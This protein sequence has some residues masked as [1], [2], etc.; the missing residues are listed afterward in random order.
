MS[1]DRWSQDD[2]E[3][4]R[5]PLFGDDEPTASNEILGDDDPFA[6]TGGSTSDPDDAPLSFGEGDTG[7]LPHW[8]EPATGEMPRIEPQAT[9]D[10]EDRKS[11]V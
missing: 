1:D 7:P 2:E 9:P 10:D 11:V 4:R 5:A 8:T 3:R 6:S